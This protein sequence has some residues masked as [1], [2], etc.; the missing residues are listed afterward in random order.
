MISSS[1]TRKLSPEDERSP[2]RV[3]AFADIAGPISYYAAQ[4]IKSLPELKRLSRLVTSQDEME[5]EQ[6]HFTVIKLAAASM[7]VRMVADFLNVPKRSREEFVDLSV[8]TLVV[9]VTADHFVDENMTAKTDRW[10]LI[11]RLYDVLATGHVSGKSAPPQ[12]LRVEKVC[13]ELHRRLVQ[14]STGGGDGFLGEF[15]RLGVAAKLQVA[16]H[17]GLDL[18]EKIGG[19]TLGLNYFIAQALCPGAI[20]PELQNATFCLG[21]YGQALDDVKDC[22]YDQYR[23]FMTAITSH[24]QP[25]KFC[26][27]VLKWGREKLI[28]GAQELDAREKRCYFN[29]AFALSARFS[30]ELFKNI[31]GS[32]TFFWRTLSLLANASADRR[33]DA[34]GATK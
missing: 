32:D 11:D 23:G 22:D 18:T 6:K 34:R 27:E 3:P 33:R 30:S 14:S 29:L 16:E 12:I 10:A 2:T 8:K 4:T 5:T 17:H 28:E 26:Q 20:R 24:A 25:K 13:Q 19:H 7:I 15:Q 9:V 31:S 21:V 1:I